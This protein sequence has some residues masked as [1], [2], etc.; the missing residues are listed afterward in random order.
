M[1]KADTLTEHIMKVFWESKSKLVDMF[2][3]VKKICLTCDL[4]TS[5]N[6]KPIL[7]I[8]CHWIGEKNETNEILLDVIE[9]RELHSE[10]NIAQR[11]YNTLCDFAIQDK[12][13]CITADNASSNLT[14]VKELATKIASF[15]K[16]Q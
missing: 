12:L 10:I 15:C 14:M 5:P 9:M 16:T 4:W 7:G 3:P 13:F 8:T 11:V 2:L 1:F 6:S